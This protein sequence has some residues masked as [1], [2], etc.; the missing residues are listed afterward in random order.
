ML[1]NASQRYI[2]YASYGIANKETFRQSTILIAGSYFKIGKEFIACHRH[3][4]AFFK[5]SLK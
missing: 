4:K 2:P 3:K 5:I 1:S